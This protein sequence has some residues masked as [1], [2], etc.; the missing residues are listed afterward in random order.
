ML[1][2][3]PEADGVRGETLG[4]TQ[5]T[6]AGQNRAI[7]VK[8]AL[9]VSD[10]VVAILISNLSQVTENRNLPLRV[11]ETPDCVSKARGFVRKINHLYPVNPTK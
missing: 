6:R 11:I 8:F 2:L 4:R 7:K 3:P 9:K 1:L 10:V 5:H